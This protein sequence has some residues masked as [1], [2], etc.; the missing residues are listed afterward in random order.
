M[1]VLFKGA[2]QQTAFDIGQK[3]AI[4]MTKQFPYPIE[5]KFEKLY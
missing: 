5:L 2:S 4:E 3:I 1:F